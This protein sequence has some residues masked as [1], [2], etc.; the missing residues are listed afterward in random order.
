MASVQPEADFLLPIAP[1]S[2]VS[3]FRSTPRWPGA[4]R[5]F[6]FTTDYV[7]RNAL[8]AL[9]PAFFAVFLVLLYLVLLTIRYTC[10]E[11]SVDARLLT[12][13]RTRR[14]TL[15]ALLVSVAL[16]F[17]IF[18][19]IALGISSVTAAN[20]AFRDA[21]DVISGLVADVS[22][23]GY[24]FVDV[25]VDVQN[26]LLSFSAAAQEDTPLTAALP[27]QYL[28]ALR[29]VPEYI[30]SVYPDLGPLTDSI[31][32]LL[33]DITDVLKATR[34][35]IALASGVLV[36][37]CLLLLLAPV[38]LLLLDSMPLGK[39][40]RP[41]RVFVHILILIFPPFLAWTMVGITSA[42]GAVL[43]DVCVMFNDY[44]QVLSGTLAAADIPENALI[45]AGATCP[46]TVDATRVAEQMNGTIESILQSPF[47]TQSVKIILDIA[48][49]KLA[50][51]AAWSRDEITAYL[52]CSRLIEFSGQIEFI[53]CGAEG[54]SAIEANYDLFVS[55]LGMALVLSLALFLSLVG[56][57]VTWSLFVW[58]GGNFPPFSQAPQHPS[59]ERYAP[60]PKS[61][62]TVEAS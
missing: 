38:L 36:A 40:S 4:A 13:P 16:T 20:F 41:W 55:F 42:V 29:A 46:T 58:Q 22:R 31:E 32:V 2:A 14:A 10:K 56:L 21:L 48:P 50:D 30:T 59:A 8:T 53:A 60:P 51:T 12:P 17:V 26:R 62:M 24:A 49:Q 25:A 7:A 45:N 44:R 19:F 27:D 43:S 1:S 6:D 52:N 9:I 54:K 23:V 28:P 47:A 3:F 34:K 39:R 5:A 33:E 35:A 57:R 18:L 37:I 15:L 11:S 61:D